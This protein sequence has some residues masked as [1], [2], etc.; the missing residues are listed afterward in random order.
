MNGGGFGEEVLLGDVGKDLEEAL[1][2]AAGDAGGLIILDD[3][4]NAEIAV[5]TA[6][7]AQAEGAEE[8]G[9]SGAAGADE[10]DEAAGR[11][12]D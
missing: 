8:S 4:D 1:V 3:A 2:V 7:R 10:G 12:T 9:F 5:F 11:N 6:G